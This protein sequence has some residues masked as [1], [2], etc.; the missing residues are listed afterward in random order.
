MAIQA[1]PHAERFSLSDNFHLI[2]PTMTTGAAHARL[3]MQT[4]IKKGVV[5][6][7]VHSRPF[8]RFSGNPAFTHRVE[9]FVLS[10]NQRMAIHA[11]LSRRYQGN[12]R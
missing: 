6:Q 7:L 1:P 11:G 9:F 12:G 3:K 2:N 4:M 5:R 8:N 10:P